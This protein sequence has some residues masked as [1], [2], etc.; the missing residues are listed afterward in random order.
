MDWDELTKERREKREA[1][2][3]HLLGLSDS[4]A[5]AL[6]I[7]DRYQRMRYQREIEAQEWVDS[8]Q[9]GHRPD[10]PVKKRY[11]GKRPQLI[12]TRD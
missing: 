9:R 4:E 3:K 7:P 10:E 12:Y 5:E 1:E 2:R 8:E 11:G 6:S